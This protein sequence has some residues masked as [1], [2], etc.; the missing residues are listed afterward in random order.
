MNIIDLLGITYKEDII[1]NLI[2]GLINESQNFR[3]SFLENIVGITNSELYEAKAFTRIATSQGIPDII[4]KIYNENETILA[5]IENKLKAEEGYNQ[6][7]RYSKEECIKDICKDSKINLNYNSVNKKFVYLTLVPEQI[8]SGEKFVNKTYKDLVDKV[9]VNIENDLLNNI[10]KDFITLM[11]NFYNNINV[12][13]EDKLLELL[14]KDDEN[15]KIYIRFKNIIKLFNLNNGLEVKHV[16]KAGG[17]G[18]VNFIA[19][20]VKRNWRGSKNADYIDGFYNV[21]ADTYDIHLE[22]SFDILNKVIKLPLHYETSPYI[23]K[24]KLIKDSKEDDYKKYIDRRNLFKQVLHKK[25]NI[26]NNPNIKTYN[27]S[28]QIAYVDI[29]I[30]E[31]ITVKEFLDIIDEYANVL[32]ILIDES[33]KEY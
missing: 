29:K 25:I 15:E 11:N 8:P 9:N 20:I 19:Q 28:N 16:G 5:I 6:T 23:P 10:Y 33:L 12:N 13:M 32:S 27:G 3:V 24:N 1:S 18:R 17:A 22:F 26:L 4:V 2:V 30:D 14:C 31:N 21:N 7:A